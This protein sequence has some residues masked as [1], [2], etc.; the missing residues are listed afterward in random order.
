MKL[1]FKLSKNMD[2]VSTNNPKKTTPNMPKCCCPGCRAVKQYTQS[3]PCL[4][5]AY[6]QLLGLATKP[7]VSN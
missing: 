2:N 7:G 4:L 5:D 1:N 3:L 6:S